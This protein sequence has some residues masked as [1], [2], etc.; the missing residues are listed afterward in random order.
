MQSWDELDTADCWRARA[1]GLSR[2]RL[3]P[4]APGLRRHR[5]G[6]GLPGTETLSLHGDKQIP[7]QRTRFCVLFTALLPPNS[8][9][10]TGPQP[11]AATGVQYT[12]NSPGDS[13]SL[14]VPKAP[15]LPSWD[16]QFSDLLKPHSSGKSRAAGR[17]AEGARGPP[18]LCCV[19]H[20]HPGSTPPPRPGCPLTLRTLVDTSCHWREVWS[21]S[22]K[23]RA[24]CAGSVTAADS[25]SPQFKTKLRHFSTNPAKVRMSHVFS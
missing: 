12:S 8:R 2:H 25:L 20:A 1:P 19:V 6:P 11:G 10:W 7:S 14:I 17:L 5:L 18:G 15:A 9:G 3:G 13:L 4:R 16:A 21:H 22:L 23:T 24:L